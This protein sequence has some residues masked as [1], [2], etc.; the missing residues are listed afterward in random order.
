MKVRAAVDDLP[1]GELGR[2]LGLGGRA[3]VDGSVSARLLAD[4]PLDRPRS[5]RGTLRLDPLR[6]VVAGEALASREPII[7][8]FD[9]GALRVER[10]FLEGRAGTITGRG[11]LHAGGGLDA[12]LQG[13]IP[14]GVLAALRPEVEAASGTL[15]V[16]VT[17]RGTI[18]APSISGTGALHGASVTVRGY[19]EPV[20]EIQA[21]LTAS[22]AGLR[23]IEARGVLGGGTLT[24]SGETALAGGGLGTYRVALTARRVAV[25]PLDGLSTALGRRLGAGGP[26]RARAAPRGAPPGPGAVHA[27]ARPRRRR[28]AGVGGRDAVQWGRAPVAD[29]RQARR[30][31]RGAKPHRLPAGRRDPFRRRHHGGAGRARDARDPGGPG[32]VPGSPLHDP[33]GN[34]AVRRS[35]P[36]GPLHRCRRHRAHPRVRRDRPRQRTHR[37]A[38][39]APHFD[40]S[41]PAGGSPRPRR[42]R[43]HARPARAVARRRP[44]R[45]GGPD[46]R[47]RPPGPRRPAGT[48]WRRRRRAAAP[49]GNPDGARADDARPAPPGRRARDSNGSGSNTSS[50]A[51]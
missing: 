28:A 20:R 32:D 37:P 14:L 2:R 3:T 36:C 12:E 35:P 4:V 50:S 25:T 43:R 8:S 51:R 45:G 42:L 27:R 16:S 33:H 49:G 19:A 44:R 48:G 17:A 22:P 1:L 24:A 31:P 7:A 11:A 6:L 40:P 30:Q 9:A 26:R 38:G 41:A 5:G 18:S 10:L 13:Q 29:R 39:R 34:G 23:L 21:R 15:D 46:H 47:P